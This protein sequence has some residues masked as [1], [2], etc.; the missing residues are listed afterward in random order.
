M[1][2]SNLESVQI[3]NGVERIEKQTFYHCTS[4]KN[5]TFTSSIKFFGENTFMQT[6]S[7]ENVYYIGELEDWLC[8]E[9]E[10]SMA[11]TPLCYTGNLYFNGNLVTSVSIPEG[12]KRIPQL[13]FFGC[14][15]LVELNIPNTVTAIG[16][17]A[18]AYTRIRTLT[19]PDSVTTIHGGAFDYC[20]DL[21]RIEIPKSV[22]Y[23]RYG[24][25]FTS[26]IEIYMAATVSDMVV[27]SG[28]RCVKKV[29]STEYFE[30]NL[31]FVGDYA[32][33]D[34]GTEV[35]LVRYFGKEKNVVLPEY[36][37]RHDYKINSSTFLYNEYVE[38]ITIPASIGEVCDDAFFRATALQKV[39]FEGSYDEWNQKY[40]G[41]YDSTL[42]QVTIV[43]T[44]RTF[45]LNAK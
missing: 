35:Y 36:N 30:S 31:K 13:S 10:T 39:I 2:C 11:A 23:L 38:T 25:S 33:Y 45:N 24:C 18:F 15:S 32:F 27:L 4:L 26:A 19:I 40:T 34:D 14:D 22:I 16:S 29:I 17:S 8:I 43:C 44:D 37:G 20:R 42:A 9:F 21:L 5:F 3:G 41:Y 7:M 1:Y 28:N 12:T 6:T